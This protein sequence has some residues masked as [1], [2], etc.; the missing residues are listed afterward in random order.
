LVLA[1]TFPVGV[2]P[3]LQL[4]RTISALDAVKLDVV[5]AE[6]SAQ[7]EAT[8]I[9]VS[10]YIEALDQVAADAALS[11]DSASGYFSDGFHYFSLRKTEIA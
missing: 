7:S 6:L 9:V 10:Y 2:S 4:F 1:E 3:L 5:D 11:V 8:V